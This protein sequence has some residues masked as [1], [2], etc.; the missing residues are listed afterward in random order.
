MD[1]NFAIELDLTSIKIRLIMQFGRLD[2]TQPGVKL[3]K[4]SPLP[5]SAHKW[6]LSKARLSSEFV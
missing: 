2:Q 3:C 4:K 6:N 5:L 1:R